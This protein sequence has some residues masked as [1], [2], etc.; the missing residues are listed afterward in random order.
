ME[1]LFYSGYVNNKKTGEKEYVL[2]TKENDL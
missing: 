2:Q 1:I